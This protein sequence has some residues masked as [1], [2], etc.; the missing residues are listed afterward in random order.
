[1]PNSTPRQCELVARRE[2]HT[3]CKLSSR[4]LLFCVRLNCRFAAPKRQGT[5]PNGNRQTAG[6]NQR[7]GELIA[8]VLAKPDKRGQIALILGLVTALGDYLIHPGMFGSVFTEAIVTGVGAALLSLGVGA[9]M[10]MFHRHN[11][12][13]S[14]G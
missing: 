9:L 1:M 2:N 10:R 6:A 12:P 13:N 14:A 7:D 8:I 11:H 3:I 4:H 5:Q